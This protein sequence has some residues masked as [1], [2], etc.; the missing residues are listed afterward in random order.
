MRRIALFLAF[1]LALAGCAP[2]GQG[3]A[4][5]PS[6]VD[7]QLAVT[8]ASVN[9]RAS[10]GLVARFGGPYRHES[11]E[12][13]VRET[14]A[15][16]LRASGVAG[17]PSGVTLLN[18]AAYNAYSLPDGQMFIS[19]GMLAMVNDQAELAAV[20]AHELGHVIS[21]HIAK[22]V[23]ER[24]RAAADTVD[25]ARA[26]GDADV[27]RATIAAHQLSLAAF[28][29]EQELEADR[30]S[31][32]LLGK[33]GYDRAG[34]LRLLQ[35]LDRMGGLTRKLA[36]LQQGEASP[37]AS[38]PPT[39]ER[40]AAVRKALQSNGNSAG[41]TG[42]E[43]YLAAI[44]GV[45]FGEDGSAGYIRGRSYIDPKRD[46]AV[47][48]PKGY[49]VFGGGA[50][51]AGV[52]QGGKVVAVFS[53]A[54]PALGSDPEGALRRLTANARSEVKI[55]PLSGGPEGAIA[56]FTNDNTAVRVAIARSGETVWRVLFTATAPDGDF[57]KD[58]AQTLASLRG[59]GDRDRQLARPLALRVARAEGPGD[60]RR[61]ADK[62]GEAETG[63]QLILAL[64]GFSAPGAVRSGAS[65]KVPEFAA[66]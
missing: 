34:V 1:A 15:D 28:S 60:V 5:T 30:I 2:G 52:K 21:R 11:A 29:R 59:L 50:A 51:L 7:A 46:V 31:L 38:H 13:L 66:P 6:L 49:L 16:L 25:V 27:T 39:P 65:L 23:V 53:R 44:S 57:D 41:K 12:A 24:A 58:V 55:A 61:F 10:T 37:T 63:A 43:T 33:A 17:L 26:F 36:G 56:A 8:D 42:R 19:R 18:S 40:I 62:V 9:R 20:M 32:D 48:F 35:S 4:L 22:R 14:Y 64:N 47:T 54:N 45:A 3:P